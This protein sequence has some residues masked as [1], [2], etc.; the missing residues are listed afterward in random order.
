MDGMRTASRDF[1]EFL[2]GVLTEHMSFKRCKLERCLFVHESFE[3]RV[4]SQHPCSCGVLGHC[5]TAKRKSSDD[6]CGGTEELESTR[7]DDKVRSSSTFFF[8]QSCYWKTA[9]HHR[10]ETG[11]NVYDKV[12]VIQTCV[13]KTFRFDTC[14]E[15]V[16]IFERNVN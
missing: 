7:R 16:Q 4:V 13:T 2:A 15:S 9:V 3:T 1:T 5:S 12:L 11:S 14:Q 6:V 8:V 10:S